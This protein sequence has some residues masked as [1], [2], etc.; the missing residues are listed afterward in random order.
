VNRGEESSGC[1]T[2]AITT[3]T[4]TMYQVQN[5]ANQIPCT[6]ELVS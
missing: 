1:A 5:A 3:R 2:T 4:S 6:L